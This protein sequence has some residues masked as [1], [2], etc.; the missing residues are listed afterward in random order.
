MASQQSF[1]FGGEL[2]PRDGSAILYPEFLSVSEADTFLQELATAK[3]WEKQEL[4]MFGKRVDEPRLSS[5]HSSGQT[6]TYSGRPRIAQPWSP[7]LQS[8]RDKCEA[9]TQ[10][11]FN[12]VLLNLYRDGKDYMGWHSDDELV[13]GP[14]PLIASISLGTERRFD[15]RHRETGETVSAML[16]HGSLLV[17]SGLSQK[18]WKHRIPKTSGCTDPRVNLTFRHLLPEC[19]PTKR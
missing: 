14:E 12:G 5:W 4:M 6:Y 17:M 15:M 2:L 3:T 8:L 7:T 10:H 18:C 16:N 19:N 13:N 11:S 9:H 1:P